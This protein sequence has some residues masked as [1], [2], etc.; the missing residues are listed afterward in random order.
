MK[1]RLEPATAGLP[2]HDGRR[3]ARRRS[4]VAA[5]L[6]IGKPFA[7]PCHALDDL[8]AGGDSAFDDECGL[9]RR[10]YVTEYRQLQDLSIGFIEK[11]VHPP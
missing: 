10:R 4:C 11:D 7:V 1:R 5:G 8:H 2:R 3:P 6:E 9:A